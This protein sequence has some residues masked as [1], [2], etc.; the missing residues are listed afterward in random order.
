MTLAV[1]PVPTRQINRA[2]MAIPALIFRGTG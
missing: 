1:I 2:G